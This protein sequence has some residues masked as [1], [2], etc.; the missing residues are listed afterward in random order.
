M[1]LSNL[2]DSLKIPDGSFVWRYMNFSKVLDLIAENCIY[3]TRLDFFDDPL[4][5]MKSTD[6][7]KLHVSNI[8]KLE[9][10]EDDPLKQLK[11][12]GQL[13]TKKEDVKKWQEG[14]FASCWYLTENQDDHNESLAM[15]GLY[16]DKYSFAVKIPFNQLLTALSSSLETFNDH[17]I[18][19]CGY[20]KVSYLT[21]YQQSL[22]GGDGKKIYPSLIKDKSFKY[23][24]E[25]RLLLIRENLSDK[26]SFDRIGIKIHLKNKLSEFVPKIEILAH[27]DMETNVFKLFKSKF[28]DYGFELKYSVLLTRNVV[29][30]LIQ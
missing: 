9:S 20:G 7:F 24:N 1:V 19:T 14:I 12:T 8:S 30:S 15:W 25:L 3:Y 5:G 16:T 6:R 29:K 18:T 21:L 22:L 13:T 4:E 17:E 23:E 26:N 11:Q 28:L 2:N 10:S 27:P